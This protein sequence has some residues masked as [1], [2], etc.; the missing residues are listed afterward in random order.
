MSYG[1][2]E[3]W[4]MSVSRTSSARSLQWAVTRYACCMKSSMFLHWE[5]SK[6]T[7]VVQCFIWG[8]IKAIL[9]YAKRCA[10]V[11]VTDLYSSEW[12]LMRNACCMKSIKSV[13]ASRNFERALS[14][15]RKWMSG[16]SLY[17]C[18]Y[19]RMCFHRMYPQCT[20]SQV[21]FCIEKLRKGVTRC[22]LVNVIGT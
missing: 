16:K 11:N 21:C 1:T 2:A 17:P 6:G 13:F 15:V 19:A 8:F 3:S 9:P 22:A 18:S 4:E 7:S 5:T 14:V 10:L 12:M 20:W